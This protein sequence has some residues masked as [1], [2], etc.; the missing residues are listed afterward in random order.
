MPTPRDRSMTIMRT[1][2]QKRSGS[3]R[4]DAF[5]LMELLIVIAVISI[6]AG[7]LLPALSATKSRAL[8]AKCVSNKKQLQLAWLLYAH[9]HED[10][11][12]PNGEVMP[13]PPQV[14]RPYWWAQ[15]I[16]D[17]SGSNSDN[18][19]ADLLINPRYAQLGEYTKA[20]D[21]YKCPAD[22]SSVLT[23]GSNRPRV[24][25]VSM[26]VHVGRCIDC[27]GDHPTHIGPKTISGLPNTSKQ[28]VFIDEHPDSISTIAFWLNRGEGQ[29]A[30]IS[31]FPSSLHGGGATLSF[32]DGHAEA[33]RWVD[34]RTRPSWTRQNNLVEVASP[35]NPDIDW[36]QKHTYFP[37]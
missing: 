1:L 34:P 36:L 25:S 10:E 4:T 8:T 20:A 31:S 37:P 2:E 28:F 22:R 30:R 17:Y 26:N 19:N 11:M 24:R 33:K 27:F 23:A 32:A 14:D 35:N 5:S 29:F 16:L 18:T 7:L 9:D 21:L 3:G 13:G 6:L 12:P 15:G